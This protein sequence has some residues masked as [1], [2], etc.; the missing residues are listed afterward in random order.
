MGMK[1]LAATSVPPNVWPVFKVPARIRPGLTKLRMTT[2]IPTTKSIA[3]RAVC[4][5]RV[6]CWLAMALF[7]TLLWRVCPLKLSTN[8]RKYTLVDIRSRDFLN[9]FFKFLSTIAASKF[10]R[11]I[12]METSGAMPQLSKRFLNKLVLVAGG[13]G[14]LG[15]AVSLAF[16]QEG[17]GVA[18][19][20]R[21][22][23]EFDAVQ[24][25]G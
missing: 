11:T 22:Q 19:T 18:V 14:G 21:V 16:L 23:E 5:R 7:K 6:I 13:T 24:E 1:P 12:G 3:A 15:R 2:V 20:F 10:G 4:K 8:R 9:C 17:A 25:S